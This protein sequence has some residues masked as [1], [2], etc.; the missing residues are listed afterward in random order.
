MSAAH[1]ERIPRESEGTSVGYVIDGAA[2]RR[3]AHS[4]AQ[5][6]GNAAATAAQA[7]RRPSYSVANQTR[8]FH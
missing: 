7:L 8:P 2:P 6:Q 1:P 3:C 5:G 4:S